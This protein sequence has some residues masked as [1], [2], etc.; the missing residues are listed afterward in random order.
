[1][2]TGSAR[3]VGERTTLSTTARVLV[4]QAG[5][6]SSPLIAS[7]GAPSTNAARYIGSAVQGGSMQSVPLQTGLASSDESPQSVSEYTIGGSATTSPNDRWTHSFVAGIDGY[8]L[9]NVQTNVTPIPSVVDS[10]LRAAEGGADRATLRASS[11]MHFN[12]GERTRGTM[13]LAAEHSTLRMATTAA[14]PGPF[15]G[16]AY[17]PGG[18]SL[19]MPGAPHDERITSWQNS[20]GLS[21]QTSIAWNDALFATGG[22]RLERDSRLVATD[23]VVALPMLGAASV[24][25]VGPVT[26]K[27]RAAYGEGIRPPT[28]LS[29]TQLWQ[30]RN[31]VPTQAPLGPERQS[32]IESGI[33]VSLR[34]ALT[35]QITRFDQRAS[36]LIQQVA[37]PEGEGTLRRM[38]YAA[39]N[40]GEI[41]NKGWELQATSN[42]SHLAVTGALSFVDSRVEKL[43]TGYTGDLVTGD[44]M[45]QVPGRTG[46][47]NVAWT[48]DR[49]F[50]S[51]SGSRALDW[52]NYDELSLAQAFGGE[53]VRSRDLTGA[54]LRDYWTHYDGGLHLRA[55]TAHDIRDGFAIQLTADNLLN[56]Q[57]GEP[58]NLTIVPGRTI[59]TGIRVKF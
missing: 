4:E 47:V 14:V 7:A 59:M 23:Q 54:R 19:A 13:T 36:G 6:P 29:A 55:T 30:M 45:L 58:D 20:T 41:S 11:K 57:R 2:A 3:I 39:Q 43:A 12:A 56:Y 8:R 42:V 35:F 27:L 18:L 10:A 38:T 5:T 26:V 16:R 21:G 51:L 48:S 33:D 31:S 17:T 37:I 22:V 40:V 34:Q 50:A 52:I 49:W 28:A 44:R 9:S 1:M 24:N 15:N 25:R 46:S 32:G 53:T